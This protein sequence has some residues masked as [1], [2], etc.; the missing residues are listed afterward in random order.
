MDYCQ[1]FNK[2]LYPTHRNAI[3][4]PNFL[5][6]VYHLFMERKKYDFR[7]H[8]PSYLKIVLEYYTTVHPQLSASIH[9]LSRAQ[10]L[11]LQHIQRIVPQ[12]NKHSHTE[13][14]RKHNP[15]P[16]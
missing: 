7:K 4:S 15:L 1:Y 10:H 14:Q 6:K 2:I 16:Y 12:K 5:T 9:L 11:H 3:G 8:K 13:K